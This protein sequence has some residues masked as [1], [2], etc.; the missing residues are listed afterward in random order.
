MRSGARHLAARRGAGALAALLLAALAALPLRAETAVSPERVEAFVDVIKANDCRMTN[1]RADLVY[2]EAGFPDKTETKALTRQ[3]IETGRARI[4]DGQLV[5]FGGDCPS[6]PGFTGRERFFAVLAD[7]GCKM[8]SKQAAFLLPRVGVEMQEVR[9]L[10]ARMVSMAEVSLSEDERTVYLEQG[11]CEKFAGLSAEI[12]AADAHN[13]E[14][15]DAATDM[16][17]ARGKFIDYMASVDC[18]LTRSEAQVQ[19]DEAGFEPRIVRAIVQDL[20]AS[21]AATM[22]DDDRLTLHKEVCE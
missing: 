13:R 4:L 20:I 1:R 22:S 7:N 11:L 8:D 3:L 2:P 17:A 19:L 15:E 6:G 10:M 14:V 9:L 18:S 21:G 12:V 16:D 5:V